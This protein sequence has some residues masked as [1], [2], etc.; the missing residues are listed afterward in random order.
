MRDGLAPAAI[1]DHCSQRWSPATGFQRPWDLNKRH[2]VLLSK[3]MSIKKNLWRKFVAWDPGP[4][5]KLLQCVRCED[6]GHKLFCLETYLFALSHSPCQ[7]LKARIST[8]TEFPPCPLPCRSLGVTGQS[9]SMGRVQ[10]CGPQS[11]FFMQVSTNPGCLYLL[12]ELQTQSAQRN[13]I[14]IRDG[15]QVAPPAP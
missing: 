11:P 10:F 15:G 12:G 5:E 6:G 1:G 7:L 3:A 2:V 4:E 14:R 13:R 8:R 9:S